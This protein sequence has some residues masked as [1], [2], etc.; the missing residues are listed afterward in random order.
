MGI[1][2][3]TGKFVEDYQK[4]LDS[5]QSLF[6]IL[7]GTSRVDPEAQYHSVAG[8]YS[9]DEQLTPKELLKV[10]FKVLPEPLLPY[11]FYTPLMKISGNKK[12]GESTN[13]MG[14]SLT[15]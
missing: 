2:R 7:R 4:A 9:T 13:R 6:T 11:I 12:Y 5:G 10:F 15:L 1:F 14:W 8:L 3:E